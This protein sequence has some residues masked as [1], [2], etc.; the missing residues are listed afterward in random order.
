DWHIVVEGNDGNATT[1]DWT[2]S[3]DIGGADV[4]TS[5][6]ME[7]GPST[8]L[9]HRLIYKPPVPATDAAH[10]FRLWGSQARMHHT[11]VTLV[12]TYEF[13]LAG[14]TRILNSIVLPIEIASPLGANTTANA[15]RFSRSIYCVE[16]GALTLKQSAVRI[17]WVMA[18]AAS[19]RIRVGGQA[20]RTYTS[21]G[22]M[23][24]GMASVQQ[25][26]DSGSAQG[27]GFTL[28][29][30][31]N[32]IVVDAY[33]SST[34]NEMSNVNGY[35]VLNYESDVPSGAGEAGGIGAASHTVMS[36][37][38]QYDAALL[39]IRRLNTI[40]IPIPEANYWMVASG[41]CMNIWYAA[42]SQAV[43]FDVECLA[44]EGKGAGYYDIYA[45]AAFMDSERSCSIVYMRGR[46]TFK[47]CPQDA[48]P[49][50]LDIETARDY[51]VYC[52]TGSSVGLLSVLTYHS[53]TWTVA[54][55]LT[56]GDGALTTDLCL[57]R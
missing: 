9:F 55:D 6:S 52:A 54:G 51:R 41:F 31:L 20:Y 4:F 22:N 49:D 21:A 29:R 12:V 1:T 28:A 25:R 44:G 37:M 43:T 18:G 42:G 19:P 46:D 3:M 17:N 57:V 30:G 38:S 39:D 8:S 5:A 45:D 10:E 13:T 24:A 50:R 36:V 33:G 23:F 26:I 14:T 48:D 35:I 7:A 2:V 56:G 40:S 47:R 32:S 27:A 53:Q 15:S 34:S 16:P 11:T